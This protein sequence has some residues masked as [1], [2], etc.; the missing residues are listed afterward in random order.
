MVDAAQLRALAVVDAL[1]LDAHPGF[2]DAPGY[3][4]HL[5]PERR[6][7]PGVEHVVGGHQNSDVGLNRQHQPVIGLEQAQLPLLDILVGD[8]DRVEGEIVVIRVLVGPVPLHPDRLDRHLD[9][10]DDL[11][12]VEQLERGNGHEHQDDHRRHGPKHLDHG[13]VRHLRW[14]R[15]AR[16]LESDHH[17]NQQ[18]QHEQHDK[19][20]DDQHYVVESA[21]LLHD[22]RGRILE[23]H[24][25]GPGFVG[26]SP[27]RHGHG[28]PD[29]GDR[30]G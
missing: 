22:R 25:P 18:P 9:L 14:G 13:V 28:R 24:L 27:R 12:S 21:D 10:R 3:R 15:I 4:I 20:D 7:R 5:D 6:N 19:G 17:V 8:H 23:T 26:Q 16:G 1:A 30:E 11:L 29:Q 2:V